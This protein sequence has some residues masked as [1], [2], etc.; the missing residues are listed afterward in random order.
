MRTPSRFCLLWSFYNACCPLWRVMEDYNAAVRADPYLRALGD[1]AGRVARANDAR[2]VK[3]AR[4]DGR[5]REDAALIG[6]NAGAAA[7]LDVLFAPRCS[8]IAA[9]EA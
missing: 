4:H 1:V 6:D 5:M 9:R 3:L 7:Q 8:A 2:N